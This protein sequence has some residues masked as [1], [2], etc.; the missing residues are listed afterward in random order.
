M[1]LIKLTRDAYVN[2]EHVVALTAA[3]DGT[4]IHTLSVADN[5]KYPCGRVAGSPSQ[6]CI[7][8]PLRVADV[9]AALAENHHNT[10]TES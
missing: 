10:P 4:K 6:G 9:A 8:V 3:E 1:K 2:P 7:F 5:I